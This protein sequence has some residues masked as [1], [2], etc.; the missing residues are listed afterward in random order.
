MI[1]ELGHF[2]LILALFV[3][4]IQFG[5]PMIGLRTRDARLMAMA[6]AAAPILFALIAGSF[7]A[8]IWA[9]LASD[10][11]VTNVY[12]NSHSAKPLIYKISGVWGNHEGSMLLWVLI[13]SLFSAAVWFFGA[14][15]PLDLRSAVL[16]IQGVI[17]ATF[18]LF[19]VATSNPFTRIA[20]PPV[21]GQGLNPI[22]QDPA[23][24]IHPPLL[25]TGYVGFSMAFSFAI[26]GLLL[27]RIELG[28]GALG[29][30]LDAYS[31]D[32]P[33]YRNRGRLMVGVLHPGLGRL[34]VLGSGRKRLPQALAR[35]NGASPF[36]H[37]YGEARQPEGLDHPP[38][39][40]RL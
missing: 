10:F 18:V 37:R 29:E 33:H 32:I 19:I 22:L 20:Q 2:A 30:A 1:V 11:S 6:D 13:L 12:E 7:L 3:S 36:R 31:L 26:A 23:L 15:L 17:S 39:N 24:A 16:A 38:R 25:Y 8:L 9:H 14:N 21:E 35:R 4:L 34:V 28:M 40:S 27:G 5:A